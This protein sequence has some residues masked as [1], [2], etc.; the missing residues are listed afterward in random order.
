MAKTIL[1]EIAAQVAKK[2]NITIKAAESF[3]SNLFVVIKE[4]LD[5]DKQVKVRGLGTFKIVTVKPRESVNVNTGERVLISSHDKVTFTP[6]TTM[7]E[8]VNRPFS[9]FDTVPLEDGVDFEDIPHE[10]ESEDSADVAEEAVA[11]PIVKDIQEPKK[12]EPKV[13]VKKEEPKPEPKKPEPKAEV[14]K[15]E[16]K[17]EPKKPEPKV[18][19]KKEESKPE[20]KKP[21]P[22]VEVKKEE[23]NPEPKKPEQKVE[24]KKKEPKKEVKQEVAKA[25]PKIA[26][27]VEM[28]P[29]T[30]GKEPEKH[31]VSWGKIAALIV[32]LILCIAAGLW[33]SKNGGSSDKN[34]NVAIADTVTTDSVSVAE[35][36]P[37]DGLDLEKLNN[38]PRVRYG[39]YTIEGVDTVVTL[40]E[41]QT[42][43]SYAKATLGIYMLC[44]F[45]AL[46]DTNELSGGATMKVP[47]VKLKSKKKD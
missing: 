27:V 44:Y 26:K 37:N 45:Q 47:K 36:G 10:T 41:G 14:K 4:G 2:Q 16:P 40:R 29:Q 1:Q 34:E 33:L 46:N 8:L 11:T 5:E 9:Q 23:P 38:D 30:D 3:V 32:L 20:P 42:M 39:G 6:D 17:P 28:T 21:E 13:E 31:P 15:E 25:E 18:E 12:P 24:V 22:K 7:K 19:V 43:E 35:A